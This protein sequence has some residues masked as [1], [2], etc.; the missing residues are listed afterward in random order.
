MEI[1]SLNDINNFPTFIENQNTDVVKILD[2]NTKEAD[3]SFKVIIIGDSGIGK[4]S[5]LQQVINNQFNGDN[6]STVGFE[7]VNIKGSFNNQKIQLIIWDTCGQE[8]FRSL[9]LNYFRQSALAIIG[10]SI[11][12]YDYILV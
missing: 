5:L 1:N 3:L 10:Y 11:T 6:T 12:K 9:I 4:T 2:S 7:I 8:T